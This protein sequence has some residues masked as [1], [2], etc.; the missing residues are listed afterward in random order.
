MLFNE[1]PGNPKFDLFHRV[2]KKPKLGISTYRDQNLIYSES[3]QN[4][5]TYQIWGH[6]SLVS[7]RKCPEIANLFH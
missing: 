1:N 5:S 4:T 7:L 2:K 3:G 6:F